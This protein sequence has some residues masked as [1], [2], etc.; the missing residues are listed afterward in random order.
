MFVIFMPGRIDIVRVASAAL[1]VIVSPML[2]LT[3][4]LGIPGIPGM[5]DILGMSMPGGIPDD[6]GIGIPGRIDIVAAGTSLGRG[7][8]GRAGRG[9]PLKAPTTKFVDSFMYGVPGSSYVKCGP[10]AVP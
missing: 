4:M 6:V 10:K 5:L 8:N 7:A 2:I 3:L 1:P 9:L